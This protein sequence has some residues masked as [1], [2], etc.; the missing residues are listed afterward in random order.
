MKKLILLKIIILLTGLTQAQNFTFNFNTSGRR[1]CLVS[2]EVNSISNQVKIIFLDSLSNTSE[3]I[4]VFKRPYGTYIWQNVA[5]NLPG[6]T[7]HWIDNSVS[8]GQVW[9]YQVKRNNTWN[10]GGIDYD[11][12]G[13]T[14]ACLVSDNTNYKGQMILLV[15]DDIPTNLPAKYLRL[16]KELTND[17]WFVNEII[18]PRANSWDSGNEVV[19]IKNQITTTYNNSPLNDKPKTIF[20]LGHVPLPRCGSTNVIAPD[21]HDENKGARGC[22]AYYADIDGVF[23]DVATYNPG[24]LATPLAVNLLGDYKWDQD[25]FPS[26]IEMS[27]GRIDFA[28]LTEITIGEL[29]MLENYL[30]RLSNYRNV[31]IGFDM[32]EKSAFYYGYDN[33]NDGSYRSLPNISKPS[34]VFQN[35]AGPN[36]NQYVQNNGPFKIYM[37]NLRVPEITDW[38]TFGMNATVYSSDQSYWGFGD[39]PQPSGL[40]SRIRSL[41][42][43]DSKCLITLWTT[44][45][46]NIFHDA[47]SGTPF[48]VSMRNIMNHNANNNYLEKPPQDYDTQDWFNRTHFAF[49]G[50]PTLTLY[51]VIPPT[52]LT[53]TEVN[54]V[55]QLNWT[56]STDLDVIGYH[57]YESSSELGIYSKISTS[58]VNAN[59]FSI[60]NYQTGKWYMVKAVKLIES[61]CGKFLHPSLGISAQADLVLNIVESINTIDLVIYPNPTKTDIKVKSSKEISSYSLYNSVGSLIFMKDENNHYFKIDLNNFSVGVYTIVFVDINGAYHRRIIIKSE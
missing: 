18:V 46:I 48:G 10:Y 34:L 56:S 5:S 60:P 51:Q 43:V 13:Y 55:A 35:Y 8:A 25:F 21:D 23:T 57:I 37:Q 12:T 26:D 31:S 6:G 42:G 36:H 28:D 40:Y 7:G 16:K 52:N 2:S 19:N 27:F 29:Q 49:Y 11:A 53:I 1:V 58:L 44:T 22:D 47:C 54:G 30:D 17:G 14:M 45:G 3:S 24:G 50:D 38:Q 4:S 32:G 33:S 9:E 41:L 59:S 61:G 15:A 39:V 20:I